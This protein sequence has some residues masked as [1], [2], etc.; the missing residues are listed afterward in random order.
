MGSSTTPQDPEGSSYIASLPWCTDLNYFR[1]I[2]IIVL[3]SRPRSVSD[4]IGRDP[5]V[6]ILM[7]KQEKY[8]NTKFENIFVELNKDP[9]DINSLKNYLKKP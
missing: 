6:Q 2:T 8:K 7:K 5:E 4:R 3:V 9:Y 1:G